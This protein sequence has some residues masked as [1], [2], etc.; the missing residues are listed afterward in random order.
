LGARRLLWA[1]ASGVLAAAAMLSG[2]AAMQGG[3]QSAAPSAVVKPQTPVSEPAAGAAP[4]PVKDA[5]EPVATPADDKPSEAAAPAPC[6]CASPA[7][8]PKRK[9]KSKRKS[10]QA[11]QLPTA[12][13]VESPRRDVV[14][15]KVAAMKVPVMSILG[16]RVQGPKGEDMGRVVDVLA[17]DTG[18]VRVAIIDFGGF[19]G[20]GARRIAVDWPLLR[21]IPNG[22]DP[23]L[24]LSLSAAQLRAAPEYKD[25]PRPQI[26]EE[27]AAATPAP[28]ADGKR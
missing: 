12:P 27:P 10:K 17:D 26:L 9:L 6:T 3:E 16:K 19:L 18:Q 7:P 25:N 11:P 21:F 2:C 15:A 1:P 13:A 24:V 28:A 22:H 4:A 8:R 5:S 20:V 23:V 14:E